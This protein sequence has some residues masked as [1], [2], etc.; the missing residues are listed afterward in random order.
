MSSET[1]SQIDIT[2]PRLARESDQVEAYFS[3]KNADKVN[4]EARIP[5][6]NLGFST[7]EREI[8]IQQNRKMLFDYLQ[9]DPEWIAR[10]GQV[11]SS[12]VKTVTAGGLYPETD[13]LVTAV[14][15]LTLAVQ[16]ADCAAVL[17]VDKTNGVVA[18]VHA[19][20]RGALAGIVDHA[21]RRMKD[22]GAVVAEVEVYISPC[23]SEAHF[24]VGE[25]VAENFP[26]AFVNRDDYRKPH[27]NLK[28]YLVHQLTRQGITETRIEVDSGCTYSNPD[29]YYSYR[30]EGK[31]S[32]RMF[33]FIKLNQ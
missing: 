19:G 12:R 21:L 28:Q 26:D 32:G 6:L 5:G 7:G 22:Q 27:V 13:G 29:Q 9:L 4:R 8:V 18:A 14:P 20:W 15:G 31:N 2:V 17:L 16:V 25:E 3:L 24:E 1:S 10:G 33:A 23:I 30:R 11:H